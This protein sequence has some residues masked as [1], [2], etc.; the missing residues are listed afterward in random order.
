MQQATVKQN[1]ALWQSFLIC[2]SQQAPANG[3]LAAGRSLLWC[4]CKTAQLLRRMQCMLFCVA[5]TSAP[6]ALLHAPSVTDLQQPDPDTAVLQTLNPLLDQQQ[7][8]Y[9]CCASAQHASA[10]PQVLAAEGVWRGCTLRGHSSSAS[11][12][13]FCLQLSLVQ[14]GVKQPFAISA[15]LVCESGKSG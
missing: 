9:C 14:F 3:L 2:R 6:P 13:V 12:P 5:A 1:M 11:A 4:A 7:P 10:W 15:E 8:C